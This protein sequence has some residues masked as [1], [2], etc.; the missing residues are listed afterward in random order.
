MAAVLLA[1]VPGRTHARQGEYLQQ[2][3]YKNIYT[4]GDRPPQS[5][6]L[7]LLALLDKR[8]VKTILEVER[9]GV[10]LSLSLLAFCFVYAP[11]RARRLLNPM[12]CTRR[13]T[14]P[15]ATAAHR[16]GGRPAVVTPQ[17]TLTVLLADGMARPSRAS[18]HIDAMWAR[19]SKKTILEVS[20]RQTMREGDSLLHICKRR[21][22]PP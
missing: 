9:H 13:A 10:L 16:G 5:I 19:H 1:S 17:R 18:A 4:P 12:I 3:V 7:Y 21:T 22:P 6:Y 20:F 2:S 15:L 14:P 11:N 8:T